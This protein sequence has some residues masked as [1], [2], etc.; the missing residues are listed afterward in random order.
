MISRLTNCIRNIGHY[1]LAISVQLHG[2]TC[3]QKDPQYS[4]GLQILLLVE[5]QTQPHEYCGSVAYIYG[6]V[7]ILEL[8]DYVPRSW[9]FIFA[10]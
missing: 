8:P 7:I 1:L 2:N 6:H 9:F 5:C 4:C 10:V 3:R